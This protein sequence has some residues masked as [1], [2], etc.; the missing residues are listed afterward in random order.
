[1]RIEMAS[2]CKGL[3]FGFGILVRSRAFGEQ[4][5]YQMLASTLK[6]LT[7]R[8]GLSEPDC[9]EAKH[10]WSHESLDGCK[11]PENFCILSEVY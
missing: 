3:S 4:S 9:Q 5:D 7:P 6:W 11:M 10:F 1:M 2:I 8:N